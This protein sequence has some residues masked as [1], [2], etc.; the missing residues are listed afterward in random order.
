MC[1]VGSTSTHSLS[2]F[3]L[4]L[5]PSTVIDLEYGSFAVQKAIEIRKQLAEGEGYV[6]LARHSCAF[7]LIDGPG[8]VDETDMAERLREVA[9]QLAGGRVDLFG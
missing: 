3:S 9:E 2:P 8:R 4:R 1:R 6:R 5:V 7:C